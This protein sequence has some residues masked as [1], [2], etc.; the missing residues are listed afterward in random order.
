MGYL[1]KNN[2]K[3]ANALGQAFAKGAPGMT[4]VMFYGV[5]SIDIVLDRRDD[6]I[7]WG[8]RWDLGDDIT[9]TKLTDPVEWSV[10]DIA[11][12]MPPE[13]NFGI[14]IFVVE[15]MI[16]LWLSYAGTTTS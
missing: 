4:F 12:L 7:W 5:G 13:C 6:E 11:P 8:A 1:T 14:A 16:T 10:T 3:I 9:M 2:E 15:F